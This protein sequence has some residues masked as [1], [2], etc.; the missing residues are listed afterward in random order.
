[1]GRYSRIDLKVQGHY[2]E[3]ALTAAASPGMAVQGDD[4]SVTF[5]A[6]GQKVPIRILLENALEGQTVDDA[7]ASGD[8]GF[9][10]EPVPGDVVA[11]LLT[12][13]ETVSKGDLLIIN[14]TGKF[15]ETTGTPAMEAFEALEALSPS[16][17]DQLIKAKR[18]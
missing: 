10:C 2:E 18:I 12:D 13:G 9:V 6:A 3:I 15:I 14:T 4:G 11:L 8:V 1:M 16:G 5:A 17:S 7:Y